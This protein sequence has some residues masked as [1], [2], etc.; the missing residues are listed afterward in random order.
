[1]EKVGTAEILNEVLCAVH[2]HL[3]SKWCTKK[4]GDNVEES[5]KNDLKTV[6]NALKQVI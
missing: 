3:F 5:H 4:K 2:T 1:M 6:E